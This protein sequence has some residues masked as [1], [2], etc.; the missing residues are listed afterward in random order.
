MEAHTFELKTPLLKG[1]RSHKILAKTDLM[2]VAI[3][4][5]S[6]GGE[7]T[8]HTHP[9]ED[10]AF[11]I[12]D[13]EATFYDK[14][15]KATVVKKGQGMMLPK[16]CFYWFQSTGGKPLILLRFG[17]NKE[18]PEVSRIGIEGRPLPGDSIENKHTDPVLIEGSVWSL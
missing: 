1:G 4:C 3:K 9:A 17:A 2:N 16:G 14:D 6:E 5:Y 15:E 10:H 7:N 13:G 18:R 12:L 8:L 11:I